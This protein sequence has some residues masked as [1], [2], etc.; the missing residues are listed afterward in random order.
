MVGNIRDNTLN[1]HMFTSKDLSVLL[2][3]FYIE[4]V[5]YK[6]GIKS[7]IRDYEKN[8]KLSKRVNENELF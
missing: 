4:I 1:P 2:D 5:E 6:Y 7:C 3:Q 8:K